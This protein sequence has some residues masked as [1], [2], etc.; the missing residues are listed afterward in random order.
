MKVLQ[1]I[2]GYTAI[3]IASAANCAKM[4]VRKEMNGMH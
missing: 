4:T 1:L 2:I 3:A